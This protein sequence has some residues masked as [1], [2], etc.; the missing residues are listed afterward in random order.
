MVYITVTELRKNLEKY[1]LLSEKENVYV[2][3]N[4]KVISV[5]VNPKVDAYNQFVSIANSIKPQDIDPVSDEDAL[6]EMIDK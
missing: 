6:L 1:L 4:N 5:L 2:T 3:K